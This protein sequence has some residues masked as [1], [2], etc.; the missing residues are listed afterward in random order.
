MNNFLPA[1]VKEAINVAGWEDNKLTFAYTSFWLL[2]YD[3]QG[4]VSP[5][6]Q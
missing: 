6:L 5:V 2:G 3:K 4:S 1:A